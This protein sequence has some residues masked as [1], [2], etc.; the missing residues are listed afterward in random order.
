MKC[1]I[2]TR[3]SIYDYNCKS[4]KITREMNKEEYKNKLFDN[5]R[6]DYKFE[7][8]E[9]MTIPSIIN[10]TNQN[11]VWYIYSSTYLPEKY[12]ER[13]LNSTDKYEKI[14]V[15]FVES[16]YD[17]YRPPILSEKFCTIRLDDDDALCQSFIDN[18]NKY[19]YDENVNCI[20]SHVNGKKFT[21]KYN[22]IIFGGRICYKKIGLGLCGI[23]INIYKCGKHTSTDHNY[24]V[25]YDDTPD[26]YYLCC[27]EYGDT[28]R[29]LNFIKN[30]IN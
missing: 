19:D 27:S 16:F 25:I 1:Y 20:I 26:M 4:F 11:Y 14:K 21:Y 18:L 29:N 23:G 22:K 30:L 10:Q 15:F 13:L 3:F 7:I 5:D 12:K 6:L 9:K 8:F 2:I 24:K 28:K 17:F